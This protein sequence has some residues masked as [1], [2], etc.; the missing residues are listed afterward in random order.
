MKELKCCELM[1]GDRIADEN[2]FPMRVTSVGEDWLHADFDG[3]EGDLWE[4]DDELNPSSPIYLTAEILE[5]NGFE[6]IAPGKSEYRISAVGRLISVV[7]EGVH[8][9]IAVDEFN[10]LNHLR[11]YEVPTVHR[12]QQALRMCGLTDM[13]DN[14]NMKSSDY[15]CIVC[16]KPAVDF[17]P[18]IDPDSPSRPYCRECLDAKKVEHIMNIMKMSWKK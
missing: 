12:L 9:G 6:R 7:L 16:G 3:N 13:A 4:Y 18:P 14:F 1:V 2:G 11:L 15:K 10:R 8:M 17:W 5:M